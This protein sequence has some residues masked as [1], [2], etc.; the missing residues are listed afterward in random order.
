MACT[1]RINT[2]LLRCARQY[3]HAKNYNTMKSLEEIKDHMLKEITRLSR[4]KATWTNKQKHDIAERC[5][6]ELT[7]VRCI[8]IEIGIPFQ[9]IEKA[10]WAGVNPP[11]LP[12]KNHF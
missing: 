4:S 7:L 10:D 5:G 9:E 3:S 2:L 6:Q 1:A 8:S 11:R 12:A